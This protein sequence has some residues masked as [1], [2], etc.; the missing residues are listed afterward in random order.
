MQNFREIL[1][2]ILMKLLRESFV[3]KIQTFVQKFS[4]NFH[5][6]FWRK[7]RC[8]NTRYYTDIWREQISGS[9]KSHEWNA[10]AKEIE[11]QKLGERLID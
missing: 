5:V 3:K 6:K 8:R 4:G 7:F 2:E 10:T 1:C 11:R 9:N